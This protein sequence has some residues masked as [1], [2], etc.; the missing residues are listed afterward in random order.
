MGAEPSNDISV[1]CSLAKA[2]FVARLCA[3]NLAQAAVQFWFGVT[4]IG[5]LLS[6]LR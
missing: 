5:Q 2:A 1:R 3:H 6:P 4:V